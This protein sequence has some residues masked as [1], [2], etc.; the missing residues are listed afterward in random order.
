MQ[1]NTS[2]TLLNLD[3]PLSTH[4]ISTQDS[5]RANSPSLCLLPC[6]GNLVDSNTTS[7]QSDTNTN[8]IR[9]A[10]D[11]NGRANTNGVNI[12]E[13]RFLGKLCNLAGVGAVA[14]MQLIQYANLQEG[15]EVN[16]MAAGT[17]LMSLGIA[18]ADCVS[19]FVDYN[20]KKN[21]GDGLPLAQDSIAQVVYSVS[22]K[23]GMS[24]ASAERSGKT[25]STVVRTG[26]MVTQLAQN[27][28]KI[29]EQTISKVVDLPTDI[30][31]YTSSLSSN[32]NNNVIARLPKTKIA[33]EHFSE[34]AQLFTKHFSR[35]ADERSSTDDNQV[36]L[37]NSDL[38][39]EVQ[40]RTTTFST[41]G[42]IVAYA[43]DS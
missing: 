40:G 22:A 13:K 30:T 1:L 23:C 12:A 19:T 43:T 17:T 11:A 31:E 32:I 33:F 2:S 36:Y 8:M 7:T 20:S 6:S 14:V 9:Q 39:V 27:F 4:S 16:T 3:S 34:A 5:S 10:L 25:I 28:G 24:E 21:G 35:E 37:L 26:L 38:V 29:T 15:E 41:L 42:K 18:V